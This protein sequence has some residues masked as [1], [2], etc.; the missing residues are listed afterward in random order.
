[1]AKA[2]ACV[3]GCQIAGPGKVEVGLSISTDTGIQFSTSAVVDFVK[4]SV[5]MVADLKQAVIRN[6]GDFDKDLSLNVND[7]MLFGG[8]Q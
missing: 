7:V 6:V 3:T 4:T 2:A 5:L 1:M 8:P